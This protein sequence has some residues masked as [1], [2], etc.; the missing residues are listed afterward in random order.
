MT[1]TLEPLTPAVTD[2]RR[3]PVALAVAALFV[4]AVVVV[5]PK[6]LVPSGPARGTVS[7]LLMGAAVCAL[8]LRPVRRE[9]RSGA[10]WLALLGWLFP[11]SLAGA[12]ALHAWIGTPDRRMGWLAWCTFP[13]MF[14]CGQ[15][16]T[17]AADRRI[18]LRAASIAAALLGGWCVVERAGWSLIGESF[19]GHRVGG[20]FGQPAYVGAA[21]VLLV[22]LAAAVAFDRS[23]G[24]AWRAV[25]GIGTLLAGAALLLSETRGA[26]LGVAVALVLLGARHAPFVRRRWREI[27][28]GV[29]ALA[30]L[31]VVTPLGGR[32]ADAFDLGH[33]TTRGRFDDWMTGV[34]VIEH[35]P[36]LG[37]GPEGYR[38]VFPQIVSA[39]YVH[40]NGTRVIPDRA[41]NAM[42]DVGASGGV[43]AALAYAALLALL[44][45]FAW[46]ALRGRDPTT[47]ALASAVIAYAV[48][49]QFLFPLSEVDP[50]FWVTAGMLVACAAP[51]TNRA[52]ARRRVPRAVPAALALCVLLG[53][54]MGAREVLADRLLLRAADASGANGLRDADRATRL[55]SDSIRTWYVAARV[56]SRGPALTDVDAAVA[57]V[58][59]GLRRSPRDPALRGLDADLLVERAV[60]SS[61]DA[62]RARARA[63][64]NR[65][66]ADAPEDPQLWLDRAAIAHLDGDRATERTDTARAARLQ[67]RA[68]SAPAAGG[69][70]S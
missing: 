9:W 57:R 54:F 21:A 49:Q 48:Q 39:G 12:D 26:W 46:R 66:L 70:K 60:R 68:P 34:Q 22:P 1:L 64:V 33:G 3:R 6:G 50:L 13:L 45:V 62:D 16:L 28:F 24:R 61:L 2:A 67:A 25:G 7:L 55:R 20:P 43:V 47:V 37:V 23:G 15:S 10:L 32:V 56:A 40:R 17:S 5:D 11:A 35:H 63:A 42:L 69:E 41:H 53:A 14:L 51:P 4:G 8:L 19:A 52:P 29:V 44:V 38:V 31:F 30:V 18:V 58:E 59:Q 27:A 65:D 36:V